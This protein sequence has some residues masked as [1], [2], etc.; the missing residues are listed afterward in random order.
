[1]ALYILKLDF[2]FEKHVTWNI[3]NILNKLNEISKKKNKRI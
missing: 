3:W 1:M 2:Y